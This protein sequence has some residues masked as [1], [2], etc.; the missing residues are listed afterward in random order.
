M[1]YNHHGHTPA[2]WTTV[3]IVFVAFFVGGLAVALQNWPMFWIGGVG[4]LVVGLIVGKVMQ[5][6]GL[7]QGDDDR[8]QTMYR[9]TAEAAPVVGDAAGDSAR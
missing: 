1:A 8:P 5:M 9:S 4:L 7:G 2:A 6:M 3:I